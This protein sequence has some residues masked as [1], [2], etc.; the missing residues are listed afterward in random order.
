MIMDT[1]GFAERGKHIVSPDSESPIQLEGIGCAIG[2]I[3]KSSFWHEECDAAITPIGHLL[4]S[5]DLFSGLGQ[6]KGK[7]PK[8]RI[9][10]ST[11]ESN[12]PREISFRK[13]SR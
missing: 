1:L 11:L 7:G 6:R 13:S 2:R 9:R 12:F 8:A 5:L 10:H 3:V 4:A